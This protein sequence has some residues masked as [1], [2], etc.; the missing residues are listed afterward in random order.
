MASISV[1]CS[2]GAACRSD[3]LIWLIWLAD[4]AAGVAG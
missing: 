4:L 3:W 1:S 2:A